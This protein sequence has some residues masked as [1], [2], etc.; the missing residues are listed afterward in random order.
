ML[1]KVY[2]KRAGKSMAAGKRKFGRK[3]EEIDK[4]GK[5]KL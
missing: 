1:K 5:V 4:K 3:R 2:H